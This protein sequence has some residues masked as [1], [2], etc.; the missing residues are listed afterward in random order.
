M[1]ISCTHVAIFVLVIIVV[2]VLVLVLKCSKLAGIPWSGPHFA[3]YE[4]SNGHLYYIYPI[5][6]ATL[7]MYDADWEEGWYYHADRGNE[8]PFVSSKNGF[9]W[10]L[11]WHGD[12]ISIERV[13]NNAGLQPDYY[14]IGTKIPNDY[15]TRSYKGYFTLTDRNMGGPA[16]EGESPPGIFGRV[17]IEPTGRDFWMVFGTKIIL[18]QKELDNTYTYSA[19]GANAKLIF[20]DSV[21]FQLLVGLKN[22]TVKT[23][24]GTRDTIV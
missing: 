18:F 6:T 14:L 2:I 9:R 13:P 7:Y 5:D 19:V 23:L 16:F 4:M 17:Q 22:G 8:G 11:Q 3:T 12:N 15:R 1:K 24:N 20:Y 10:V 21:N